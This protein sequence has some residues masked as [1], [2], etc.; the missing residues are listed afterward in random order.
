MSMKTENPF[1]SAVAQSV[2]TNAISDA[3][4]LEALC[5]KFKQEVFAKAGKQMPPTAV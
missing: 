3:E 1:G 4:T 2:V 5:W